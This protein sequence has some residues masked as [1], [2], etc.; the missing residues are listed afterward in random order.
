MWVPAPHWILG[1]EKTDELAKEAA[2][3]ADKYPYINDKADFHCFPIN[4]AKTLWQ[5][6]GDED[7]TQ[8][9]IWLPIVHGV[10]NFKIQGLA[11][12]NVVVEKQSTTYYLN[13][14][15]TNVHNLQM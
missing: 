2:L 3:N 6:K 5:T 15:G 9:S 12:L 1:N 11:V 10:T 7:A 8:L 13:A 4:C 14:L